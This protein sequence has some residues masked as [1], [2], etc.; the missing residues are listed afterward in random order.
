MGAQSGARGGTAGSCRL[1]RSLE[2]VRNAPE[3]WLAVISH[4]AP[5]EHPSSPAPGV[6][7]LRA[8]TGTRVA[9]GRARR[10]LPPAGGS[11]CSG[12]PPPWPQQLVPV[13]RRL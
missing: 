11:G 12:S 7:V 2:L 3:E 4:R 9:A 1:Q 5:G 8:G 6:S 10:V 13:L